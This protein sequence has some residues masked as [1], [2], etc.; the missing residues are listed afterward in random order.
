MQ[1]Q[2]KQIKKRKT[3]A[4]LQQQTMNKILIL[5][6]FILFFSIYLA[7]AQDLTSDDANSLNNDLMAIDSGLPSENN[8]Q[9]NSDG[10]P[11]EST[12]TRLMNKKNKNRKQ[13]NK[14]PN[15]V[16]VSQMTS[17]DVEQNQF[18]ENKQ[19]EKSKKHK[20]NKLSRKHQRKGGKRRGQHR[21]TSS[22][23]TSSTPSFKLD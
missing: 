6:A 14:R 13:A 4:K 17:D 12:T 15:A 10:A 5:K 19:T 20:K 21:T 3:K 1:E 16:H 8:A 18:G 9:L 2:T 22:S 7:N 23:T 11:F